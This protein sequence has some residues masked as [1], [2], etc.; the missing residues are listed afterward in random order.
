VPP[1]TPAQFSLTLRAGIDHR[2]DGFGYAE[3][4]TSEFRAV[5]S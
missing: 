4:D 1:P 3:G 2:P 5:P